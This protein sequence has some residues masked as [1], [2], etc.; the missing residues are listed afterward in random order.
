[1]KPV[2]PGRLIH[3][4][5]NGPEFQSTL[6]S[7]A[8]VVIPTQSEVEDLVFAFQSTSA[9]IADVETKGQSSEEIMRVAKVSEPDM[10]ILKSCRRKG[11]A[12]D[13]VLRLICPISLDKLR[14]RD[15]APA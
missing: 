11:V 10:H 12:L 5:Q 4:A 7:V 2:N 14:G 8:F 1:M 13:R 6:R 3:P 15:V 9:Q